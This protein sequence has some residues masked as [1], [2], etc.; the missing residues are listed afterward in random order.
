MK[1]AR[2]ML[3]FIAV[4]CMAGMAAGGG[5]GAI[6]ADV[7]SDAAVSVQ[8][9]AVTPFASPVVSGIAASINSSHSTAIITLNQ[10]YSG[11]VT[12]ILQ[13]FFLGVW[14]NHTVL[15]HNESFN[16]AI[17]SKSQAISLSSGTY[18]FAVTVTTG[19]ASHTSHSGSVGF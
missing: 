10:S 14:I 5:V 7:G 6:A 19:G 2:K 9:E 1:K 3:A 15:C 11:T 12:V 17:I 16:G 8:E 4:L 18:R 13:R